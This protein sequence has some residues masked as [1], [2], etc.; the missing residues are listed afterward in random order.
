VSARFVLDAG[1]ENANSNSMSNPK[2]TDPLDGMVARLEEAN[3][4]AYEQFARADEKAFKSDQDATHPPSD[5]QPRQSSRTRSAFL[6]LIGLP[7]LAIVCVT[8]FAW[9][10]SYGHA[11]QLI[12]AWW[13]N[14]SV[15][16]T[17]PQPQT[18]PQGFVPPATPI[19]SEL[20]QLLQRTAQYLENVEQ[21]IAEL[22][23]SQEQMIRRDAEVAE[24]FKTNQEKIVRDNAE[25]AEQLRAALAQMARD[26]AAVAGQFRASQEQLAM[27][28]SSRASGFAR[29]PLRMRKPVPLHPSPQA[30]AQPQAPVR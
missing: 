30:R 29:K 15:L 5:Q 1:Q 7:L 25:V 16:Q 8:P 21:R 20:A 11:L 28:V 2:Q 26:N 18:T 10:F 6:A 19:S 17:T 13:A 23:A 4:K 14:A 3:A 24:R 12:I 27:A 9:H 22:R